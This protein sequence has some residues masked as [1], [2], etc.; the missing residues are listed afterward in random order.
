MIYKIINMSDGLTLISDDFEVAAVAVVILGEGGYGI[1]SIDGEL[2]TPV[3]LG[4]DKW[5]DDR[6]IDLNKYIDDNCSKI[7][8]VLDSVML[9]SAKERKDLDM[10]LERLGEDERRKYIEERNDRIRSSMNDIE[11]R[12]HT[13][14]KMLRKSMEK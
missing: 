13:L 9:G 7:A 5:F 14:A 6:G 8:D 2:R 3:L 11:T 1:E 12:A 4:W 10:L